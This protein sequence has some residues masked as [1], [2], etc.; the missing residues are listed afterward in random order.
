MIS[1]RRRRRQPQ[2]GAPA[3]CCCFSCCLF[4]RAKI[5]WLRWR[6]PA[7]KSCLSTEPEM[8][9]W[10]WSG[11]HQ[12]Y[13]Y[14]LL[15]LVLF[16]SCEEATLQASRCRWPGGYFDVRISSGT[17]LD[18]DY[19][20]NKPAWRENRTESSFFFLN[21]NRTLAGAGCRPASSGGAARETEVNTL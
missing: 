20:S 16:R 5:K 7:P 10:N 4:Q 6:R 3:G 9:G 19:Q 12:F 1:W 11:T 15:W 21:R 18:A 17:L 13:C 8:T 2:R 14:Y